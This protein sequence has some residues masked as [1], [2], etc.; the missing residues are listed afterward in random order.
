M[1]LKVEEVPEGRFSVARTARAWWRDSLRYRGF[2][3]TARELAVRLFDFMRDLTPSRRRLRYGDLQYD[4]ENRVDTT[5][6]NVPLR[7]RMRE[8]FAGEQYQPIQPEQFHGIM[9][10]LG[11]DHSEFT[12]IDLGSGKGRALLLASGYPF[13]H[14][15][16]A[17]ILP[18]LHRIAQQNVR[19]FSSEKQKCRSIECWCG[20]ARYYSFPPGNTLLYLFNPFF[21]PVLEQVLANLGRSLLERPRKVLVL[22]VNPVSEPVLDRCGFLTKV[23]GT[24]QYSLYAVKEQG[25]TANSNPPSNSELVSDLS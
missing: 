9:E 17:E 14:I 13:R 23:A 16:G 8:L 12:F 2:R 18:E 21:E 4:F 22:Y 15:I 19:N 7:T 10:G 5:W 3:A 1:M 6:S 25:F 20:D 11:I 24:L